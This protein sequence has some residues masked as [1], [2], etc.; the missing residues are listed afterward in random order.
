MVKPSGSWLPEESARNEVSRGLW[1]PGELPVQPGGL[2]Y[3]VLEEI[4][5]DAIGLAVSDWP[6]VDASGRLRFATPAR[7]AGVDGSW[8]EQQLI[9]HRKP[10][11]I[12]DRPLRIGDV[13]AVA[14]VELGIAPGQSELTITRWTPPL[15]DLTA[16]ARAAA[17][18]ALY[19]AVA[20]VL[21]HEQARDLQELI[22]EVEG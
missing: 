8:L 10:A 13:F 14:D 19:G 18:I 7:L 15:Y 6:E 21:D 9:E 3:I 20:P 17:K 5:G 22:E 1:A 4:L 2:S 16:E 12:A 11:D